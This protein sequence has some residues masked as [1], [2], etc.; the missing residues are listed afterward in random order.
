MQRR[1][2]RAAALAALCLAAACAQADEDGPAVTPYRPSVSTP[3]A[4]SEPGWLELE[5][6]ALRAT[7]PDRGS[8]RTTLPYTLKLAFS[9]Q[10]GVRVGGDAWVRQA[11][12]GARATG[13]GDTAVVLKYRF[14]PKSPWGLEL[15][16]KF[17][18][19]GPTLGSGRADTTLNG[20]YS[21]DFG[22]WHTDLNLAETRVGLPGRGH[23]WQAGWA[24]SLSHPLAGSWGIGG[25]LSGTHQAAVA[26]SA[27]FLA[28]LSWNA[29]PRAAF[30]IGI[31]RGL[32]DAAPRNQV[33]AGMTVLL[34]KLF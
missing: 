20:I 26:D 33:F 15:G 34:G 19:A 4:L 11:D 13:G 29:S 10:W 23:G 31:A 30:D 7:G 16:Q 25:E 18:T 6:G 8:A 21:Q 14:G 12:A 5:A 17:P 2:T 27:Q 22:D 32:T 9:D 3:A 1:P 28:A 24:A